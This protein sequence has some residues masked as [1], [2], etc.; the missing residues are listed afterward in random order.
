MKGCSRSCC[1]R[2]RG[3]CRRHDRHSA[4]PHP[5]ARQPDD[6]R[7]FCRD[8]GDVRAAGA[9]VECGRS[10]A[11]SSM[12]R[13]GVASRLCEPIRRK[14]SPT[15]GIHSVMS[16]VS[17][18]KGSGSQNQTPPSGTIADRLNRHHAP[19]PRVSHARTRMTGY[20]VCLPNRGK[21]R[22]SEQDNRLR[23]KGRLQMT[24][25]HGRLPAGKRRQP[26]PRRRKSPSRRSC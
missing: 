3:W 8:P 17:A 11:S 2:R 15:F 1:V 6:A 14:I 4:R 7:D 13:L 12:W 5:C 9:T 20:P 25:E 24:L 19:G 26:L 18:Q 21:I 22:I 10:V 23:P 16:G